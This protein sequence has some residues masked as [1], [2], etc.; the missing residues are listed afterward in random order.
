[1]RI[2]YVKSEEFRTA[3]LEK[4]GY[5]LCTPLGINALSIISHGFEFNLDQCIRLLINLLLLL[6][7][8]KCIYQAYEVL[9]R[10]D[11]KIWAEIYEQY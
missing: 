1:M 3:V 11:E 10:L 6:T 2:T 9:Y 7:G 8:V 5:A 4:L